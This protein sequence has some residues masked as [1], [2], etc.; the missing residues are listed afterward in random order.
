ME[1]SCRLSHL[2][3]GLC[4][5]LCVCPE[6]VLWQNGCLDPDAIRGGEWGWSRDGCIRRVHVP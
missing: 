2:S 4:V 5:G 3:V 1:S 6:S